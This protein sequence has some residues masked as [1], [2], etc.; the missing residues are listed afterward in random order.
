[1]NDM[2][3]IIYPHSSWSLTSRD[4]RAGRSV[5]SGQDLCIFDGLVGSSASRNGAL[6]LGLFSEDFFVSMASNPPGEQTAKNARSERLDSP[7]SVS[8]Q[9]SE[10]RS[11]PD[12]ESTFQFVNTTEP[13]SLKD[14]K[15][16]KLVKSHVKK[17]SDLAKLKCR[18]SRD[19][20][21]ASSSKS[22]PSRRRKSDQAILA[23]FKGPSPTSSS[24]GSS[25][26]NSATYDQNTISF[27]M[28]TKDQSLLDC[29][30][31]S[32]APTSRSFQKTN[33]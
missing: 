19:S 22:E 24:P 32:S 5:D 23:P 6:D 17:R 3:R 16:R 28:T 26:P 33:D 13:S 15:L 2:Q 27:A 11:E 10:G 1:M 30:A 9:L 7:D 20:S 14:P 29:C 31:C 12:I 8:P 18:G 25:L 4:W 21:S